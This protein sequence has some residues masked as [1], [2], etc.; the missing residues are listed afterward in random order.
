MPGFVPGQRRRRWLQ[1][2][3]DDPCPSRPGERARVQA[4]IDRYF[5]VVRRVPLDADIPAVP[6]P[7]PANRRF[8]PGMLER[9]LPYELARVVSEEKAERIA[10]QRPAIQEL[11]KEKLTCLIMGAFQALSEGRYAEAQLARAFGLSKATFSRFAGSRWTASHRIPDLW[12]NTAHTLARHDMFVEAAEEAGVWPTVR[13]VL[14][15][16]G[17]S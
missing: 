5:G 14:R 17:D 4:V 9:S 3:V 6:P 8:E 15:G 11:G 13:R 10:E 1:D 2:N 7:A 16:L 12:A